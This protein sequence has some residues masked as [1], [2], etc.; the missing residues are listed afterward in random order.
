MAAGYRGQGVFHSAPMAESTT[1]EKGDVVAFDA[2][3]KLVPAPADETDP[4]GVAAE[5]RTTEAGED[6]DLAY[7]RHG[8]AQAKATSAVSAGD[9]VK[10]S[11]TA[12]RIATLADQDVD[13][14]GTA[15]YT[16][17]RNQKLGRALEDIAA[18][19]LGDIFVGGA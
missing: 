5:G 19:E 8:I 16:I 18:G 17:H 12:G 7:V 6:R 9:A 4:I 15:T 2:D 1:I 11:G 10:V 14:G 3:G 13:E